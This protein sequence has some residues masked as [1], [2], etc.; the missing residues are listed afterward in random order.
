M[1]SNSEFRQASL[2]NQMICFKHV[3]HF[4]FFFFCRSAR[5]K[6][7]DKYGPEEEDRDGI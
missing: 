4:F 2:S 7:V 5:R 1:M 6:A 3:L